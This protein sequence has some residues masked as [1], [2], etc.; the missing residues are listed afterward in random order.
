ME[1]DRLQQIEWIAASSDLAY[2]AS[3]HVQ[4]YNATERQWI[5]FR[6]WPAQ[7]EVLEALDTGQNI[8]ILKA[9]QLGISWLVLTYCLWHMVFH[10]APSVMLMSKRDNEAIELLSNRLV[11][12]YQ[13]LPE[14]MQTRG[15]IVAQS[16][17]Q[18]VLPTDSQA[19]AFPTSGGR[20]YTGSIVVLDEA[21]FIPNLSDVLNAIKPTIDAGGQLIILSTVDKKAPTSPFKSLFRAAY[22]T[23]EVQNS[24]QNALGLSYRPLF[25]PWSAR[26]D[27]TPEWYAQVKA[28]LFVQTHSNDSLYQ[29]YPETP[30]QALAPIE[31]DKRIPYEWIQRNYLPT[32]GLTDE[33]IVPGLK[34]YVRPVPGR[35]YLI[36]ADPAEGN[37]NSDPS[38][39]QVI[40]A[41]TWEQC[42]TVQGRWEPAL[43]AHYIDIVAAYYND[44]AVMT[45]RNN[46]GHA[47]LMALK[48]NGKSLTML[49]I[50]DKPG[51]LT[52]ERSKNIGWD[53]AADC[54]RT[55]DVKLHDG[56]TIDQLASIE[57]D[58]LAAPEGMH[59]DLAMAY[60]LVLS[61]ARYGH[62]EG[63]E[64][65]II[66]PRDR[67]AEIDSTAW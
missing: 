3:H 4:I 31:L 63:R 25:L 39:C 29:E 54:F 49:G 16:S 47:L 30:E 15:D 57:A 60:M 20:S 53:L 11:K 26:P 66:Q 58:T 18:F 13:R 21:D 23:N 59:D 35:R 56:P 22:Y 7:I 9:R 27:R 52:T 45:E 48:H 44:A 41:L 10:P 65:T 24:E 32:Q 19:M 37:P 62:V 46:H 6:P 50:D 2:F 1:S 43:F 36:G 61:G 51:W 28:D 40:D 12:M 55:N 17:H 42:A 64:S 34:V 8:I 33:T 5:P 67:L 14:Y 38:A